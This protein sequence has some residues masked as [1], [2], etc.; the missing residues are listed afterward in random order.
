MLHACA[1][2][3]FTLGHVLVPVFVAKETHITSI[4]T[5]GIK[6]FQLV[7]W[8]LLIMNMAVKETM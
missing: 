2:V 6:I 1:M 8:A 7:R 5:L 3:Y 4:D